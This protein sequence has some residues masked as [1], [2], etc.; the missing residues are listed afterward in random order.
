MDIKFKNHPNWIK[1]YRV[2]KVEDK[3]QNFSYS[4]EK[5]KSSNLIESK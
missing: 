1:F 3:D 5:I 2:V 4:L